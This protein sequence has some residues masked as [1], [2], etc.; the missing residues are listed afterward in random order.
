MVLGRV[1]NWGTICSRELG[2]GV[3]MHRGGMALRHASM[4][5]SSTAYL[6]CERNN[7]SEEHVT[8]MPRKWWSAPRLVIA[9]SELRRDAMQ[10]VR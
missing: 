9:N 5:R 2:L 8:V 3:H 6:R 7:Q 1:D 10:E 4:R